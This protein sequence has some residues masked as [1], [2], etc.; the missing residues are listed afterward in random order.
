MEQFNATIGCRLAD[1]DIVH[2]MTV[3]DTKRPKVGE[4]ITIN[5]ALALVSNETKC[6]YVIKGEKQRPNIAGVASKQMKFDR[7]GR[8]IIPI[9]ITYLDPGTGQKKT[10]IQTIEIQV[11]DE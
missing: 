10:S 9:S 7:P 3:V 11:T 5:T 2:F 4:T 6:E 1:Y 8:F